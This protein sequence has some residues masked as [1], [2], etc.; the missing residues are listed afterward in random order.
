MIMLERREITRDHLRPL[1]RLKVTDAQQ[2]QVAPNEF[3]LAEQAYEPAS[4]AWGLWDG[5]ILVGFMS[6]IDMSRYPHREDADDPES[7]YI[8]RLLIGKEFQGKGYGRAA[9]EQAAEVA[10]GW[11]LSKLS[12]SFVDKEGGAGPFYEKCG[13]RRTGQIIDDELVMIRK[14]GATS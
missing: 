8:W 1:F 7:A 3:S 12:L 14:L 6:M 13:F 2:D 4:Q 11:G 5:D 9:I 10:Q